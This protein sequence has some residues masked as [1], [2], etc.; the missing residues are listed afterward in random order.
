MKRVEIPQPALL[1]TM[2]DRHRAMLLNISATGAMLRAENTP[3]VRREVFLQVGDIDVFA[4]VVW[5]RGDTCGLEFQP[6]IDRWMVEKL[7]V[8]TG[9][10]GKEQL[11]PAERGGADD[12]VRGVAR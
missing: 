3:D 9:C 8:D 10:G 4:H 6:P 1:I 2:A 12:W 7:R 11:K 5:K